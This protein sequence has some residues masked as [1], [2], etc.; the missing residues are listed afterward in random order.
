VYLEDAGYHVKM[1]S[2]LFEG[3]KCWG[4]TPAYERPQWA[5]YDGPRGE[6]F[7]KGKEALD[8]AREAGVFTIGMFQAKKPE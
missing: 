7:R 5:G 6:V 4:S 1:A 8:A 3:V 2:D